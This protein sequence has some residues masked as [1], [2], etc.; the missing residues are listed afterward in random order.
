MK[1]LLNLC[2]LVAGL[3]FGPLAL[4]QNPAVTSTLTAQRVEMVD[5]KAVLKPAAQSKPGE[6]I[7]YSGTYRN[8]SAAAVDK[9]Q[10]VVPVPVGTTFM[11]GS[12]LPA[13][14]QASTD[15]TRF[16]PMPLVRMVKQPNGSEHQE[17]VPLSEYRALR[18][19]I[20][21]LGAGSS[22]VVSLRVRID[23]PVAAP[24]VKP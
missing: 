11:A 15:G 5:G 22:T 14:A 8:G 24:A 3:A 9:L 10:A 21:T 7:E 1:P 16:A 18:W 20:G 13:S 17:T 12:T 23:S 6:I 4:A 19:D 2:L